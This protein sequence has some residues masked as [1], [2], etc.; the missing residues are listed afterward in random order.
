MQTY[1]SAIYSDSVAAKDGRLKVGDQ[2]LMVSKTAKMYWR[3]CVLKHFFVLFA[4]LFCVSA[5]WF[6]VPF[7]KRASVLLLFFCLPSNSR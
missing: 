6:F 4:L 5:A 7:C 1:I 3:V 2:I